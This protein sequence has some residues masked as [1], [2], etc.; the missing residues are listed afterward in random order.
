MQK[1]K[2]TKLEN[3]QPALL[4]SKEPLSLKYLDITGASSGDVIVFNST[5]GDWEPGISPGGGL[6]IGATV[7][8]GTPT[9]VLY[10]DNFGNLYS[11]AEFTRDSITNATHIG[12]DIA[13][14]IHA[15]FEIG[16]ITVP[17]AQ[18]IPGAFSLVDNTLTGH[19][20]FTG[21]GDM[22]TFGG[23]TEAV[24]IGH[25]SNLGD[26][27]AWLADDL[28]G[29][30]T[31][32]G[33]AYYVGALAQ[34]ASF[35][36]TPTGIF[37]GVGLNGTEFELDDNT[38]T[39][40]FSKL[41]GGGTQM[42]V[43]DNIGVLGVQAIPTPTALPAIFNVLYGS[44]TSVNS[45]LDIEVG[46]GGGIGVANVNLTGLFAVGD[47][48]IVSDAGGNASG[49]NILI[50]AQTGNSIIGVTSAQTYTISS[51]GEVVYLRVIDVTL[52]VT[53]WKIQ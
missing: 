4:V 6:I 21:V 9:E 13:P 15:H 42:V 27:V 26:T 25:I 2:G 22:T 31:I 11:D 12:M 34:G 20:A 32:L 24:V 1:A 23:S 30:P 37:Y 49:N 52:G 28:A 33:Q 36:M 38:Q 29:V 43:A 47:L 45:P 8:G 44:V 17:V 19:V 3:S 48:V 5:T 35:Q 7:I 40:R 39:Y 41:G 10:T 46:F 18:N 50:D 53:T 16:T 14:N 51:D